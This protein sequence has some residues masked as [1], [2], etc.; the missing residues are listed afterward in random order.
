MVSRPLPYRKVHK[1]LIELGFQPIRQ[2]GSH[3]FFENSEGRTTV[4][5][6]HKGEDIGRGLIRKICK[7]IG[8]DPVD[9]F[10]GL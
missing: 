5:P 6:K 10:S 9:F 1:R 2:K 4:V 3:V 7:D 8:I